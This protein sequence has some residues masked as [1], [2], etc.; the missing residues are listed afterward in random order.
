MNDRSHDE[1]MSELFREDPT[2]AAEL[3]AAVRQD[4]TPAELAIMLRQMA[5]VLGM[6]ESGGSERKLAS[7]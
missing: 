2:Y 5:Y 7:P 1:A 3:L 4:G 6:N